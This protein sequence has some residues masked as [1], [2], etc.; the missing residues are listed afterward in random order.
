MSAIIRIRNLVQG[1]VG[2]TT[3]AIGRLSGND[4]L[5]SEA[6]QEHDLLFAM[7]ELQP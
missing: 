1:A 4:Q 6:R 3:G 7:N 2:R 5:L